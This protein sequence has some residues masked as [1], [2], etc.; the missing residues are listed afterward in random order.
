MNKKVERI[1]KQKSGDYHCEPGDVKMVPHK[2][3]IY[4]MVMVVPTQS[5]YLLPPELARNFPFLSVQVITPNVSV[6]VGEFEEYTPE[7]ILSSGDYYV[8]DAYKS[9]F[10]LFCYEI[11]E[12]SE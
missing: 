9:N 5:N 7:D 6:Y 10:D 3:A 2:P 1:A 12:K 8:L 11:T 4:R